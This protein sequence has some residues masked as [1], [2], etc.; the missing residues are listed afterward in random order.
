VA[1]RVVVHA[2]QCTVG[3]EELVPVVRALRLLNPYA[4][5]AA[6]AASGL[7]QVIDH[8]P[9][10][11]EVEWTAEE[12]TAITRV[13]RGMQAEQGRLPEGLQRLRDTLHLK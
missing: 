1:L 4:H 13:L 11:T 10:L 8:E 6:A 7:T 5:P 9:E 2:Q 3:P 12:Q